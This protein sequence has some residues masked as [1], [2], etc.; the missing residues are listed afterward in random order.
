MC[1]CAS[2][3][4]MAS[5]TYA[6]LPIVL[7][8]LF[9]S[10][11]PPPHK[12]KGVAALSSCS[13]VVEWANFY[14]SAYVTPTSYSR[15]WRL[16]FPT[17]S[18]AVEPGLTQLTWWNFLIS[19]DHDIVRHT[20]VSSELS[21][22]RNWFSPVKVSWRSYLSCHAKWF[23]GELRWISCTKGLLFTCL[24]G[25]MQLSAFLDF[26]LGQW[27]WHED[28]PWGAPTTSKFTATLLPLRAL[29]L[30]TIVTVPSLRASQ[31]CLSS[32]VLFLL[33]TVCCYVMLFAVLFVLVLFIL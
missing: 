19:R 6:S 30:K 10:L 8:T 23:N 33:L 31:R 28:L 5:L 25:L 17:F 12:S 26:P 2:D 18:G 32:E 13:T 3:T 21:W 7:I 11:S 22:K 20:S 15:R 1:G 24:Y 9:F 16:P 4:A 29:Q 27:G 14:F